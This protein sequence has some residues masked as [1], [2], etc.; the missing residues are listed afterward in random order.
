MLCS[1]PVNP[2]LVV[3][4]CVS[5]FIYFYSWIWN[6][7]ISRHQ[8]FYLKCRQQAAEHVVVRA[9]SSPRSCFINLP[10]FPQCQE[11]IPSASITPCSCKIDSLRFVNMRG[12]L[13]VEPH[14]LC[15]YL[16]FYYWLKPHILYINDLTHK[17]HRISYYYLMYVFS[18]EKWV[19]IAI[20]KGRLRNKGGS[21]WHSTPSHPT[22]PR[23]TARFSLPASTRP[24]LLAWGMGDL[25]RFMPL[26]HTHEYEYH[27]L[28]TSEH[29]AD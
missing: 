6:S 17:H 23:N 22:I 10:S 3:L 11:K 4:K 29:K 8:T 14:H 7:C 26:H 2:N 20:W 15:P 19:Q 28:L 13:F 9:K 18:V 27:Y 1:V 12:Y 21:N 24:E 5:I 16:L 25:G